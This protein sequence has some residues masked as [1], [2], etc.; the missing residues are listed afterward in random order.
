MPSVFK[1][2]NKQSR[3]D[4]HSQSFAKPTLQSDTNDW[5]RVQTPITDLV[6]RLTSCSDTKHWP[7]LTIDFVFR[8]QALTS[9]LNGSDGS[10]DEVRHVAAITVAHAVQVVAKYCV[11]TVIRNQTN[12]LPSTYYTYVYQP[13]PVTCMLTWRFDMLGDVRIHNQQQKPQFFFTHFAHKISH[14][15]MYRRRVRV[16]VA[17]VLLATT[18]RYP[19]YMHIPKCTW[20]GVVLWYHFR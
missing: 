19:T 4:L 15:N 6:L 9:F 20:A 1:S 16:N 17:D 12:V 18:T 13:F 14:V 3:P 11:C 5:H 8:H 10:G 2:V 7:H